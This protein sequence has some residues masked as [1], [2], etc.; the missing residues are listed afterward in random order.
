M[1]VA[2][3]VFAL[4]TFG[5]GKIAGSLLKGTFVACEDV[6]K[7]LIQAERDSSLLGKAGNLMEKAADLVQNNPVTK[8]AVSFLDRVGL[9][10]LGEGIIGL[11]EKT[12]GLLGKAGT[13]ALEKASPSLEKTLA[14]VP[15]E[16]K[17][18]E[19]ALYGGEQENLMLTRKMS[20]IAAR[21]PGSPEVAQLGSTFAKQLNLSRGA[22][23]AGVAVD[24]W[25]KWAGGLDLEGPGGRVGG[26]HV[27]GTGFYGGFKDSW[28]TEGGL[29]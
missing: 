8:A 9:D 20:A 10:R 27:P 22:F 5:L 25:D 15:E 18:L 14:T 12:S 13:A 4:A 11:T 7:G 23:G 19:T 29:W 28:T 6:T 17:P 3:D 24:Q 2:L 1:D 16:M 21:F 26:L